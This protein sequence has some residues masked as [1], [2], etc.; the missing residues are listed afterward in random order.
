[1]QHLRGKILA[2][3]KDGRLRSEIIE[4]LKQVFLRLYPGKTWEELQGEER[5]RRHRAISLMVT[6]TFLVIT[7]AC[8]AIGEAIQARRERDE[9]VRQKNI[10]LSRESVAASISV[11]EVDPELSSPWAP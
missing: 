9:A 5:L 7:L 1:M 10:A 6:V 3:P 2:N 11:R 8:W 4:N